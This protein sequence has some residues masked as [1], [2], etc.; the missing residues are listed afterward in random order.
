MESILLFLS[1][2][3][4]ALVAALINF[5]WVYL[6][7]KASIWLW[8]V[9]IILPIFY[10]ILSWE[11]LFLGNIVVNAYYFITSII[12]WVHWLRRSAQN[13]TSDKQEVP[14]THVPRRS[15]LLHAVLLLGLAYPIYYLFDGHSSMPLADTLATLLSFLGMIYLSRKQIEHWFCWVVA[16]SLSGYIFFM[17]NDHISAIVFSVN[18]IVSILGYINWRR[19]MQEQTNTS[20]A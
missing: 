18:L 5:V 16:N 13:N 6:E 17:A 4:L 10:I 20:I 7:Y 11:A 12:G 3:W 8:P 14:I 2:H 15:A 19:M 9:G 1:T